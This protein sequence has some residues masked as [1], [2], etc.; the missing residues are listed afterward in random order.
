MTVDDNE[1]EAEEFTVKEGYIHY[2]STVKLVCAVTGMA[3]PR[4]VSLIGHSTDAMCAPSCHWLLLLVST[5]AIYYTE[6]C[7]KSLIAVLIDR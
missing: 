4:L 2:G 6:T 1:S 5:Q 3:L 7:R